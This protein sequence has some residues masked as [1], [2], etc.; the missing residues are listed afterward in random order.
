[1]L[2][3]VI[4]LAIAVAVIAAVRIAQKKKSVPADVAAKWS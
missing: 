4:A 2:P 1:V 3:V